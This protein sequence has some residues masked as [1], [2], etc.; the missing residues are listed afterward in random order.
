FFSGGDAGGA[1]RQFDAVVVLAVREPFEVGM[2][3]KVRM[4][5]ERHQADGTGLR[6]LHLPQ[7]VS[8]HVIVLKRRIAEDDQLS[9]NLSL[10]IPAQEELNGT[11]GG[12][13]DPAYHSAGDTVV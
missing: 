10:K 7:D 1:F 13:G 9:L 4:R 6:I 3:R 5:I 11:H 12:E 2:R 8:G